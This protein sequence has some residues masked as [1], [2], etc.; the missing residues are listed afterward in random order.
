M[1]N[2]LAWGVVLLAIFYTF[3]V[4][5]YKN[6]NKESTLPSPTGEGLGVRLL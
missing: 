3:V 6:K 2:I 4:M 1:G 5:N